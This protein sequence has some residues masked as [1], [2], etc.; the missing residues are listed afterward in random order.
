LTRISPIL[1][2]ILEAVTPEGC[3]R[4]EVEQPADFDLSGAERIAQ[5]LLFARVDIQA[6]FCFDQHRSLPN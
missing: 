3:R 1:S 5:R 6:G 4:S 2:V